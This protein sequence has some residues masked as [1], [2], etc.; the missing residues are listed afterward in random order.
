MHDVVLT[1]PTA[2]VPADRIMELVLGFR[3]SR[4]LCTAVELGL[5]T[6]LARTPCDAAALQRRLGLA[7]RGARD[8]FDA[9][10][11][12]GLVERKD[13][14]YRNSEEADLYLV[15]GKP[16]Y[17]GAVLDF[18][19]ARMHPSWQ[20]LTQALRSGSIPADPGDGGNPFKAM[21]ADPTEI[22]LFLHGLAGLSLPVAYALARRP[23]WRGCKSFIDVGTGCGAVAAVIAAA[24]PHLAGGGFD[25]PEVAPVFRR[26]VDARGVGDRLTFHPGDFFDEPLPSAEVLVMGHIL[27]DW[28]LDAKRM[29]LRKAYEA[30]PAGGALLVYDQMIDDERRTNESGLLM[31][32]SM[33]LAT[34][35]GFDY[36]GSECLAWMREA[37]FVDPQLAPLAGPYSMAIGVK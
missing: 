9:L 15:R 25:L 27:H 23:A 5:F 14:T 6:E 28:G 1:D 20:L 17:I 18:A 26:Y 10:V 7:G 34:P 16:T 32:L 19:G 35:E 4:V 11:A 30:L 8:F 24:H 29:L 2:C 21:Y 12:L 37:G 13:G 22:E 3:R 36:T 31:S 33:L